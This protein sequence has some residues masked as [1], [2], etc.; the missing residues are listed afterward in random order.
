MIGKI[1]VK[2][3]STIINQFTFILI[4]MDRPN[5]SFSD[6]LTQVDLLAVQTLRNRISIK[7]QRCK[8]FENFFNDGEDWKRSLVCGVCQCD[9]VIA[10]N[11]SRLQEFTFRSKSC[12]NDL[13][14]KLK[15][16]TVA[17]N[18]I[19]QIQIIS[20][21]PYLAK[22]NDE[23]HKWTY[24]VKKTE[25]DLIPIGNWETKCQPAAEEIPHNTTPSEQDLTAGWECFDEYSFDF[26]FD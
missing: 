26:D 9:E 21:I 8:R 1:F 10:V 25:H 3:F 24:R 2:S 13:F 12:L 22:H 19:N 20:K 18:H 7:Y 11:N 17:I 15:Y 23:L 16:Q 6:L 4:H 5:L 14:A